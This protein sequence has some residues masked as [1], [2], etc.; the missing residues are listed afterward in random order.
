MIRQNYLENMTKVNLFYLGL[1]REIA[2]I[3]Q[4][5][6]PSLAVSEEVVRIKT[7]IDLLYT[8]YIKYS[9]GMIKNKGEYITPYTIKLEEM[10]KKQRRAAEYRIMR[11][12]ENKS[13]KFISRYCD[14]I[15]CYNV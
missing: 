10:T 6:F 8:S 13:S 9:K 12:A 5:S 3:M 1:V 2:P 15:S 14:G 4:Y 7:K 11:E